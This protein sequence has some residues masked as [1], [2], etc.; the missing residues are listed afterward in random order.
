MDETAG[1]L[2]EIMPRLRE[3]ETALHNG[4]VGPRM[5]MWSRKDPLTVLGAA[6]S[7][8]GWAEIKPIFERVGS[9]FANCTSYDIEVVAAEA[10]GDLAYIVGFEHTT[11]SI[12]GAP[13]RAYTLRVTTIFRREDGTWKV[14]H[15]HA[16]PVAS[17][18]SGELVQQL[19][20]AGSKASARQR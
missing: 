6:I 5:A 1:F 13:P 12:N 10:R 11:A 7:G 8:T 20:T 2:R 18:T 15:R 9:S 4:D 3:A 14:V 19:R 16:D 17:E